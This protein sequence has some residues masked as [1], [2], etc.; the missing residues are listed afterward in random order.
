MDFIAYLPYLSS[1]HSV[2]KDQCEQ[3]DAQDPLGAV[4]RGD[5]GWRHG[6]A[7]VLPAHGPGAGNEVGTRVREYIGT[8]KVKDFKLS[9]NFVPMVKKE[10][11]KGLVVGYIFM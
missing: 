8:L 10:L 1:Q 3:R 11:L 7:Q 5:V 6:G 9:H 2:A 4:G